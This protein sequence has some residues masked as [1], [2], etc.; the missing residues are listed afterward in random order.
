M[1]SIKHAPPGDFEVVRPTVSIHAEPPVAWIDKIN[2]RHGTAEIAKAYLDF[3]YTPAGQDVIAQN[4]YRPQ[5]ATVAAKYAQ[6][7]PT[8]TL[9]KVGDPE[10]GGWAKAQK[11]F[12]ADGGVF[13]QIYLAGS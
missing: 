4:F 3:L 7:F 5:D 8:L 13:D 12:F 11:K 1:T 6:Q 2:S 9:F 10:F